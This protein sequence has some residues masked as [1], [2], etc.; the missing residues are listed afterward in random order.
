MKPVLKWG[1]GKS[2]LLE[3]AGE[4]KEPIAVPSPKKEE[5]EKVP[6]DVVFQ[7]GSIAF[8]QEVDAREGVRFGGKGVQ[9][10]RKGSAPHRQVYDILSWLAILSLTAGERCAQIPDCNAA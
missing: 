4:K 6:E 10:T 8:Q 2:S 1:T 5:E 7:V 9:I 3:H